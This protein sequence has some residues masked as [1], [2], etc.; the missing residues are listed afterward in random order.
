MNIKKRQTTSFIVL[1]TAAYEGDF[2]VNICRSWHQKRGWLCE[3]YNFIILKDGMIQGTLRGEDGIGA[4]CKGINSISI[5]ICMAGHG[6]ISPWNEKQLNA[7]YAL[8][9]KLMQKYGV[10]REQVIGHR[11][12]GKLNAKYATSKSCPGHQISMDRIREML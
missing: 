2:D 3:G 7:L 11:E 12:I 5:G 1:H 4:H 6:D 8:L 10:S 9:K